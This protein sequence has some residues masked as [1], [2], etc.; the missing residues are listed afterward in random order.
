MMARG[1]TTL[2]SNLLSEHYF[3]VAQET[4][5]SRLVLDQF[6]N[7]DALMSANGKVA[8]WNRFTDLGYAGNI[9]TEGT[10]PTAIGPSTTKVSATIRERGVV[11]ESSELLDFTSV[12]DLTEN[13]FK[14]VGYTAAK[15]IDSSIMLTF[16]MPD[17]M[18]KQVGQSTT[19]TWQDPSAVLKADPITLASRGTSALSNLLSGLSTFNGVR[20]ISGGADGNVTGASWNFNA[21]STNVF[22]KYLVSEMSGTNGSTVADL[23][24]TVGLGAGGLFPL[25]GKDVGRAVQKLEAFDVERFD[26]GFYIGLINSKL[27]E[28]LIRDSE[29]TDAYKYTNPGNM[30]KGEAGE[31]GG[32]RFIQTEHIL[33]W[34]IS[35]IN[36]GAH[37]MS[38][39]VV[40]GKN[41]FGVMKKEGGL[42]L[43]HV[44]AD[45]PSH[46]DPLGLAGQIGARIQ[47]APVVLD[48]SAGVIMVAL[49]GRSK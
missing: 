17:A 45:T 28:T 38:F 6:A 30:Y 36:N 24:T 9:S 2:N 43:T 20:V 11:V 23:S 1:N 48:K 4:K 27:K 7:Q 42:K 46:S 22:R 18:V 31:L 15:T 40:F 10:N 44:P 41:A 19:G 26:D 16:F 14:R 8:W 29:W 21:M 39:P 5:E 3:S 32:V 37:E 49:T 25:K 33:K 35:N 47:I 13:T 12:C 34:N